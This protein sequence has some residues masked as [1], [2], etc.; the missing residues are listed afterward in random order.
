M[1]KAKADK[2][3]ETI[4]LVRGFMGNSFRS[5]D[6][7]RRGCHHKSRAGDAGASSNGDARSC[8]TSA[9]NFRTNSKKSCC[10]VGAVS[11][12]SRRKLRVQGSSASKSGSVR[13]KLSCCAPAKKFCQALP[14]F[15]LT[16]V[17]TFSIVKSE[18]FT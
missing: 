14:F 18:I 9:R 11:T 5:N 17:G 10:L 13:Y 12:N 1:T 8:V 2:K 16:R 7:R 15:F 3:P 6:Q 4:I